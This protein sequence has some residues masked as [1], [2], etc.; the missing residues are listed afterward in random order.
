[1]SDSDDGTSVSGC[2]SV[3]MRRSFTISDTS[4]I[5]NAVFNMD[6]DDGFVA[7]LN[8]VEI[9][10]VNL[11]TPGNFFS[12]SE[13][14]A[15]SHE[16]VLYQNE[17]PDSIHLD[18]N[19]VSSLLVNRTNVLAVEV[20]N[21]SGT[22]T[23]MS[24]N[25][26]LSFSV[27]NGNSL[28]PATP[29]WFHKAAT[30][31]LHANFKLSKTGETV[32][33]TNAT[34]GLVDKKSTGNLEIDN[35]VARIPDGSANWCL[36]D[37]PTPNASNN[38]TSCKTGYATFPIFSIQGGFYTGA[39]TLTLSTAFPGGSI[40]YTTDGSDVKE[41]STLYAGPISISTTK[42][43]RARVFAANAIGS[44]TVTHT[45]FINLTCRLPIVALTTDPA[46][47]YDYNTGIFADGPGY[48]SAN[49]H[50]GANY[51][52][53]LEK[54]VTVEYYERDKSL[55]FKFNAGLAV[56]GG[57]SRSANQKSL[58]IKLGDKY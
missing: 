13:Y 50:F 35:S 58:E 44:S 43:I 16:A 51:W 11:G 6:F 53:D 18:F 27:Q 4:K 25:P 45:Y 57:W 38:S 52:L 56:T 34:S 9:A 17:Y 41:N 40:R 14:A 37:V 2:V 29:S 55:Q 36:T 3:Y 54:D 19:S 8:G 48:T 42:T 47:L 28:F 24:S 46:N 15:L 7:Y 1:M 23:D 12:C 21:T 22:Y 26:F 39:R 32:F 10:R 5:L 20:H 31:Y 30:T 49:P 33:L